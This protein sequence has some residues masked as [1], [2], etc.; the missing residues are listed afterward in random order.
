MSHIILW[1]LLIESYASIVINLS[2]Y[3][4]NPKLISYKDLWSVWASFLSCVSISNLSEEGLDPEGTV[5]AGYLGM[6]ALNDV[7]GVLGKTTTDDILESVF[8][9][10]CVGK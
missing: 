2:E 1:I 6:E 7:D 10:F 4:Y 3:L 9:N 5:T 8:S